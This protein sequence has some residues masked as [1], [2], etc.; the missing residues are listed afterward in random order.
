MDT[1]TSTQQGKPE[2]DKGD[3]VGREAAGE[4][5]GRPK[6]WAPPS[7]NLVAVLPPSEAALSP[8]PLPNR[9]FLGLKAT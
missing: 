1:N 8:H 7:T 9:V 2:K 5:R 6:N 4:V 3:Q